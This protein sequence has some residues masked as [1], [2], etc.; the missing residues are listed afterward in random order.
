MKYIRRQARSG[1]PLVL[2]TQTL[3]T[4]AWEAP[5]GPRA[6][7]REPFMSSQSHA[8][9]QKGLPLGLGRSSQPFATKLDAWNWGHNAWEDVFSLDEV[10]RDATTPCLPL[11]TRDCC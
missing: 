9:A 8:N 6:Q 3:R 1:R 10:H 5:R 4:I 11:P 2:L 7:P